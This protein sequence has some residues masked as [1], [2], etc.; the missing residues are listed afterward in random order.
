VL[1]GGQ[2]EKCSARARPCRARAARTPRRGL[3]VRSRRRVFLRSLAPSPGPRRASRGLA[4]RECL[5]HRAA[6]R[7]REGPAVRSPSSGARVPR[8]PPPVRWSLGGLHIALKKGATTPGRDEHHHLVARRAA[9]SR[10]RPSTVRHPSAGFPIAGRYPSSFLSTY[11]N[12]CSSASFSCQVHVATEVLQ[13]LGTRPNQQPQHT[14]S[15]N[16]HD[17][18]A[19]SPNRPGRFCWT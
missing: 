5:E 1:E 19:G 13:H 6:V 11:Q 17:T 4:H 14:C 12:S 8:R 15:G 3:G 7:A 18:V 16:T 2:S 10:H 9:Q